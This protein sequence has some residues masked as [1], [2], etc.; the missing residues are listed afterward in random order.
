MEEGRGEREECHDLQRER[1]RR[2]PIF[3]SRRSAIDDRM[4]TGRSGH[5]HF[6][7]LDHVRI[8]IDTYLCWNSIEK[9][10]AADVGSSGTAADVGSSGT[11]ADVGSSGAVADVGSS[12]AVVVE[13]K[14]SEKKK[15]RIKLVAT[16]GKGKK[17]EKGVK[18]KQNVKFEDPD[19][20]G[21]VDEVQRSKSVVYGTLRNRMSPSFVVNVLKK[22]SEDKLIAIRAIGFGSLEFLKVSQLPL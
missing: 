14:L 1:S 16:K 18:E 4:S 13:E 6:G 3:G 2:V 22:L 19:G 20:V 8:G 9:E 5:E 12:G 7:E 15:K 10:C 21:V 17:V 11:A